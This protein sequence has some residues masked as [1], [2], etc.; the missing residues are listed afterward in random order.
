MMAIQTRFIGPGNAK[1]SRYVAEVMED[2][3]PDFPVRRIT[4]GAD[5][6]LGLEENHK[7]A[8]KALIQ[9]LEWTPEHGYGRWIMGGTDAGYVFVCDNGLESDQLT[10]ETS[11]TV[12]A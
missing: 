4:L 10:F 5:Y 7:R 3:R 8:A 6:R 9:K 12:G 1:G 2:K 11:H